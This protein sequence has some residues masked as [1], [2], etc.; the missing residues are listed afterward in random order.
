[1]VAHPD[2]GQCLSFFPSIWNCIAT[3][4]PASSSVSS[5]SLNHLSI[6]DE[7]LHLAGKRNVP[8]GLFLAVKRN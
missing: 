5:H 3:G 4:E 6:L 8:E 7:G 2:N 1:M